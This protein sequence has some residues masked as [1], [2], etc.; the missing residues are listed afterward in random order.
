MTRA[1]LIEHLVLQNRTLS[2]KQVIVGMQSIIAVIIDSLVMMQRVEIRRFGSWSV[3]R[4]AARLVRNPKTGAQFEQ[5]S[6]LVLHF[7]P[8]KEM[9]E[10]VLAAFETLEKG[11]TSGQG[12]RS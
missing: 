7:K 10:R 8:A 12:D 6:R 1:E 9:R 3:R 2:Q 4:R 11:A 5:P